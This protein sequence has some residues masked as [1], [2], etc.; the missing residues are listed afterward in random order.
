MNY[1]G[2]NNAERLLATKYL[3]SIISHM[4]NK[5]NIDKRTIA[6]KKNSTK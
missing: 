4:R 3:S 1:L 6:I 5:S 2:K